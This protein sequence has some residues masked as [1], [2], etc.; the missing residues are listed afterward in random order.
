[1]NSGNI[2]IVLTSLVILGVLGA[3]SYCDY[4]AIKKIS[5]AKLALNSGYPRVANQLVNY[6]RKNIKYN[7]QECDLLLSIDSR[8]KLSSELFLDSEKCLFGGGEKRINPYLAI[9]QAFE[10][11]NDIESA[12]KIILQ[13][14][15][16]LNFDKSLFFRLAYL[17]LKEDKKEEAG[18]IIKNLIT[19]N[20]NDEKIILTSIQFFTQRNEWKMAN[21]FV[22]FMESL[23]ETSFESNI[24]LYGVAKKN[25]DNEREKKYLDMIN[26]VLDKLPKDQAA[27][28]L[29]RLNKI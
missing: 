15:E 27:K 18:N 17:S 9:S 19:R 2:L 11:E 28:I 26:K 1:M 13:T 21:N 14:I 4:D 3:N 24:T 22:S 8:L 6:L 12:K 5:E 10:I 7:E 16:S 20:S 25:G 29:E 23:K